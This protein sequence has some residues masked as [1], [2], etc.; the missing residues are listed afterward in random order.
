MTSQEE[1]SI[2]DEQ[3]EAVAKTLFS[4]EVLESIAERRLRQARVLHENS[5][6]DEPPIHVASRT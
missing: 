2:T 4:S 1:V 5:S 6:I 3:V